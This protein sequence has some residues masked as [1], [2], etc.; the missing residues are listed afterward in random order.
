MSNPYNRQPFAWY[1]DI[2]REQLQQAELAGIRLVLTC[3]DTA[4]GSVVQDVNQ[5]WF[6]PTDD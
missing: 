3:L 1:I 2:Q 4:E 6:V 5:L